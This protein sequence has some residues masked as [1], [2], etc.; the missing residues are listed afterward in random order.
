MA[1]KKPLLDGFQL[2]G[3]DLQIFRRLDSSSVGISFTL[4]F[5]LLRMVIKEK[6]HVYK[7]FPI[8]FFVI[9]VYFYKVIV[10]LIKKNEIN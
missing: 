7:I 5:A 8:N 10:Y 2:R 3:I 1:L 4:L 6:F 9:I